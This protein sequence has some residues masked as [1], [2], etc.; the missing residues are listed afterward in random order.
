MRYRAV[1]F[2]LDGT[3]LNTLR[4]LHAAVNV[5]L[6]GQGFGEK[7]LDE[8]RSYVGNGVRV[9]FERAL[10]EE[11]PERREACVAAFKEYYS[12]HINVYTRPY[13]GILALLERLQKAGVK[14]GVCSNKFD[15]AVR[16]LCEAHFGA[17][18]DGC[19]GEGAN[20][21]KKP[22]PDGC[23]RL[24]ETWGVGRAE[25]LYVG[26]SDVDIA[27]ARNAGLECASVTWG[28]CPRETMEA[29]GA[30]R[31]FADAQALAE[32]ILA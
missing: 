4:D 28:F 16:L 5:A 21:P 13:P 2:D 7:T 18:L 11:A 1:I 19:I 8:V 12:S 32:Y 17:L 14:T 27:T 26:D 24:M 29:A 9:L 3:L 15:A 20:M 22:A 6:K 30:A 23:L 10:P 31:F 25:T